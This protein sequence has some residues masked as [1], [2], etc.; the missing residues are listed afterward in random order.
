MPY[1][2]NLDE[3]MFSKA[4]EE[5]GDKITVS[6]YSYNKGQQKIQISRE[7][8]NAQGELRYAKLGRL[9][10]QEAEAV[11]PLIREAVETME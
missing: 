4:W 8:R 6:V 9:T 5:D 7:N 2:A 1:D 11:L 3:V 10:K